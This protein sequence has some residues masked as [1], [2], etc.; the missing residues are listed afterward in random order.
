MHDAYGTALYS[1]LH[2]VSQLIKRA[3]TIK[4]LTLILTD[5]LTHDA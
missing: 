5:L 4:A 3:G 2:L 1:L